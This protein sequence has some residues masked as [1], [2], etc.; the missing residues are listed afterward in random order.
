MPLMNILDSPL[1]F[2]VE[3]Q[4]MFH[5]LLCEPQ[6]FPPEGN[7]LPSRG[8]NSSLPRE[9]FFPR[10]DALD[11]PAGKSACI[12]ENSIQ[13]KMNIL[14]RHIGNLARRRHPCASIRLCLPRSRPGYSRWVLLLPSLSP[15][16][17][18]R[19]RLSGY[20]PQM[21]ENMTSAACF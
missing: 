2:L 18:R 19:Q 16:L 13:N 9:Y 17:Y 14:G 15:I 7:I 3:R 8:N 11:G 4:A 12:S 1:G 6:V 5:A 20:A 21:E 10:V